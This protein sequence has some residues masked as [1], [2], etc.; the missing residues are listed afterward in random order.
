MV[1]IMDNPI[2]L[3]DD[4]GGKPTIFGNI[5]VWTTCQEVM[6]LLMFLSEILGFILE[7]EN[8]VSGIPW[9]AGLGYVSLWSVVK[10]EETGEKKDKT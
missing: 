8:D 9:W 1:K 2:F 7:T 5:H 10:N 4:L 3:M 6:S